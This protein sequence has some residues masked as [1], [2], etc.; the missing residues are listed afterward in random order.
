METHYESDYHPPINLGTRQ[1]GKDLRMDVWLHG[2][3]TA[4][5]ETVYTQ[6]ESASKV[7]GWTNDPHDRRLGKIAHKASGIEKRHSVVESFEEDFFDRDAS[8]QLI[9]P[10]TGRRNAI[11]QE[12][13]IPL[14]CDAVNRLFDHTSFT[15]ESITHLITV[16]CTG[17]FN[18]GPDYHIVKKCGL[19]ESVQRYHLGFMGCYAAI[20]A[21][22]MA[23][24]FCE[25]D[26]NAVV[27]VVCIELCSLHLKP[28]GGRDALLANVLFADGVAACLVSAQ[29]PTDAG[30]RLGRRTTHLVSEGVA[31]MAWNIG[32]FGFD[33]VLSSYIPKLIG[34][35][36]EEMV[37]KALETTAPEEIDLWAVHPGGKAIVD[38]VQRA[39]NLD[40][41]QLQSSRDTL[42]NYGNMSS[43]TILFVLRDLLDTV[44]KDRR[45]CA[46][47]FGPGLT[48]ELY[49][50]E[51]VSGE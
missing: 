9:E 4:V 37:S 31:E 12:A 1:A 39:L 49:Q 42:R 33:M 48:V 5:P 46:M 43:V 34:S 36:I 10:S 32:D 20:S 30:Y 50:M 24:Q 3:T 47:A 45:V 19:A 35:N 44:S 40:D 27:L 2:I 15:R 22:H 18:P 8:G 6:A 23:H 26:E 13:A 29:A 41:H 14:A 38:E 17:F 7:A 51:L 25:A 16:S 11:F 21:V 28:N